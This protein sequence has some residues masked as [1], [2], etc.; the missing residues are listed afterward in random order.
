MIV[1]STE[2]EEQEAKDREL[3]IENPDA[4]KVIILIIYIYNIYIYRV[5]SGQAMLTHS[6]GFVQVQLFLEPDTLSAGPLGIA[7]VHV[8][9]VTCDVVDV[10][11]VIIK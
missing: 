10:S 9:V 6:R 11:S 7:I 8:V 4:K 3:G 5:P 1:T 2:K